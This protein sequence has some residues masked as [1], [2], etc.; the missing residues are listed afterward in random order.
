[1]T[2]KK[3]YRLKVNK[4]SEISAVERGANQHSHVTFM[5]AMDYNETERSYDIRRE[6]SEEIW[7]ATQVLQ[8]VVRNLVESNEENKTETLMRSVDQFA[9]DL[10]Q[11]LSVVKSAGSPGKSETEKGSQ[12]TDKV[13]KGDLEAKVAEL[14]K[15]L[16]DVTKERDEAKAEIA[17]RDE[18]AAI[19]KSDDVFK[20]VDGDLIKKSEVGGAFETLKKQDAAIRKMQAEAEV[21]KAEDFVKSEYGHLVGENLAKAWREVQKLDEDVREVVKGVFDQAEKAAADMCVTKGMGGEKKEVSA[22]EEMDK[23][24]KA[25]MEKSLEGGNSMSYVDAYDAVAKSDPELYAK[26]VEGK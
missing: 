12:M 5:K 13:E 10:K 6:A 26:A 24:A 16:S 17:K 14:E 2:D 7:E 11:K 20:S 25:L 8:D 3:R 9:A 18:Q 19:E 15:S 4:L 22:K 1:M 21:R 23:K